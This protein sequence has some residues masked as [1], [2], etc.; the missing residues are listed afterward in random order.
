MILATGLLLAGCGG[1]AGGSPD[2][3]PSQPILPQ[4]TALRGIILETA[5]N[6]Q[7]KA[8]E[9][10]T[11]AAEV[12]T[13]E[14]PE[15]AKTDFLTT[16]TNSDG[17]FEILEVPV[18]AAVTLT[19]SKEGYTF[20]K[21]EVAVSGVTYTVASLQKKSET[22]TI[23]TPSGG[24]VT[25]DG[26]V[27]E[28]PAGAL[29]ADVPNVTL[30][31]YHTMQNLPVPLPDEAV[32][33]VGADVSA[34]TE[35]VFNSGFG[36]PFFAQLPPNDVSDLQNADIRLFEF[37]ADG[38]QER[39]G[40]GVLLTTGALAGF[41]GPDPDDPA[42]LSGLFPAVY[43]L[44]GIL[45]GSLTGTVR[46]PAGTP[47]PGVYVFGGGAL[48]I[49]DSN[50]NYRLDRV[51]VLKAEGEKIP[52][53]AAAFGS[54]PN[55]QAATLAPGGSAAV[56]FI[57]TSLSQIPEIGPDSANFMI[58]IIRV[59]ITSALSNIAPLPVDI[60]EDDTLLGTFSLDPGESV[61][62]IVMTDGS[63]STFFAVDVLVLSGAVDFTVQGQTST[64]DVGQRH[65]FLF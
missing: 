31:S 30:T 24:T 46:D 18:G 2:S 6:V 50:G 36:A 11:I 40:K 35:V 19:M 5:G 32:P 61:F 57:L 29:S 42:T 3:S 58:G 23:L 47:L 63:F 48:G 20:T 12:V 13:A 62:V 15:L 44:K 21:K 4:T 17:S 64:V 1:A 10:V 25:T 52:L 37:T 55:T 65:L 26:S 16:Q 59:T 49:T 53:I 33:L 9:N 7:T 22:G 38:W 45:P 14:K 27:L 54:L 41:L 8:A 60:A 56:D 39:P 43:A 51:S 34:P 28:V